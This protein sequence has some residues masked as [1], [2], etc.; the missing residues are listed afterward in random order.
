LKLHEKKNAVA[1][2]ALHQVEDPSRYG[3]AELAKD[4]RIKRFIEKPPKGKAPTN[5][6]NAGVYVLSPEIFKRI[7]QDRRVS[8]EREVFTKLA[9]EGKLYGY[10]Y[11]GLWMDIGKPEDYL[12]INRILADAISDQ[13][14]IKIR[15]GTK[16]NK[17]VVLD[18]KV[19]VGEKSTIGP[20]VVLGR[21]VVV[22]KSVRIQDSVVLRGTEISDL[23]SINGAIIGEGVFIGKNAKINKGCILGDHVRIKDNTTL[24]QRVWIC[25]AREVSESVLTSK[26]I[27]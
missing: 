17:P 4:N 7:P 18:N 5:L 12:K 8:I 15:K 13:Q 11:D 26:C 3:V 10:I 21:N 2:M 19:T 22:G 6:I 14:K 20:Y 9:E 24:A 27:V 25:P 23:A 1:T 16:V